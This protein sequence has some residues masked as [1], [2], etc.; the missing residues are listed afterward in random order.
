MNDDLKKNESKKNINLRNKIIV[1]YIIV[2]IVGLFLYFTLPLLAVSMIDDNTGIDGIGLALVV[3]LLLNIIKYS[4]VIAFFI[5]NPIRLLV[6][7]RNKYKE[8]IPKIKKVIYILVTILPVLFALLIVFEIPI[9][10]F[11]Y[12]LKYETGRNAYTLTEDQYKSP[13]DFQNELRKRGFIYDSN[14]ELSKLNSKYG[15][16]NDRESSYYYEAATLMPLF[17]D[18]NSFFDTKKYNKVISFDSNSKYQ[19]Y[20]YNTILYLD[21]EKGNLKY[22]PISRYDGH[23]YL[24][25]KSYPFFEDYYI[26]FKILYVNEDLYAIIGVG[27]SY[28]I[29]EY[30]DDRRKDYD[31]MFTYPYNMILSENETITTCVDGKYYPNGSIK[32]TGHEFEMLP[33]TNKMDWFEYYEVRKVD[34]L[35]VE[36]VNKIAKELQNSILKESIKYHFEK[37]K[38]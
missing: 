19:A 18:G 10:N 20:I 11:M 12:W 6:V 16:F 22:A 28:D 37:R 1:E 31:T 25:R 2:I 26:E 8:I 24:S 5:V 15:D 23:T 35:N 21:D 27:Q 4:F 29:K 38:K 30:F 14:S 32:N 9:S 3:G 36:T 7:Y 17:S 13:K 34:K 33:N